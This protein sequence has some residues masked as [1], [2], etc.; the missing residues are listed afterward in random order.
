MMS[1][2]FT[3]A[4]V[5]EIFK[6]K[7]TLLHLNCIEIYI[8]VLRYISLYWDIYPCIEIYI[9]VLRYKSLIKT[10]S[11]LQLDEISINISVESELFVII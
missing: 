10:D 2:E 11:K 3:V 1:M 6:K 5:L 4:H 7:L 8:P 9:P